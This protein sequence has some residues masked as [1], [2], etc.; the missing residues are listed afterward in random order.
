ML[1]YYFLKYWSRGIVVLMVGIVIGYFGIFSYTLSAEQSMMEAQ[2]SVTPAITQLLKQDPSLSQTTY[3]KSISLYQEIQKLKEKKQDTA[4]LETL[5][6]DSVKNL[7][8]Q[9]DTV[10]VTQMNELETKIAKI[11]EAIL[12]SPSPSTTALASVSGTIT[13]STAVA[14]PDADQKST[15]SADLN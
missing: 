14:S 9:N 11:N 4:Q 10:A 7:S 1:H 8:N 15:S 5:Y 13:P 12:L 6:A 3:K 2:L